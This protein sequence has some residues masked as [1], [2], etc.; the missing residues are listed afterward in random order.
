MGRRGE[1]DAL[2][3]DDIDLV[4]GWLRI[5]E[6]VL[7]VKRIEIGGPPKS[8][9]GVRTLALDPVSRQ[10]LW[11]LWHAQRRRYGG[12]DPKSRMFQH[13]NGR[14]VRPDWLTRRFATLVEELDL[15]PSRLHDL[16]HLAAG[17]AGAAGWT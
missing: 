3:W 12:V 6:Q 11:A 9:A 14:A 1:I 10:I 2:R 17:V 5:R 16:R 15:P 4:G 7:I 13:R 8:P